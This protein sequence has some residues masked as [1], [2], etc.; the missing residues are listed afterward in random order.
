MITI[1]TKPG[2]FPCKK[3]KE[4]FDR[5]DV[6]YAEKDLTTLSA[7]ELDKLRNDGFSSAPIVITDNDKWA[8]MNKDKAD[9]AVLEHQG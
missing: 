4:I 6:Q 3:T 8:G 7:E 2:C 1:M 5:A 9:Q